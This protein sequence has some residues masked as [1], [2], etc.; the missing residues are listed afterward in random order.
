MLITIVSGLIKDTL[1]WL[2]TTRAGVQTALSFGYGNGEKSR[3]TFVQDCCDREII[4][5]VAR[6]GGYDKETVQDVMLDA[7]KN[8]LRAA[9]AVRATGM[10]EGQ[11]F[12]LKGT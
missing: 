10:A 4:D 6:T 2:R 11:W 7:V 3:V 12:G 1:R 5:W 8:T 9:S